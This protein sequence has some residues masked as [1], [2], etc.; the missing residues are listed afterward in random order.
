M[1]SKNER[2]PLLGIVRDHIRMPLFVKSGSVNVLDLV[3]LVDLD[4]HDSPAFM[5]RL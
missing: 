5:I 3:D 4:R 2:E 1:K